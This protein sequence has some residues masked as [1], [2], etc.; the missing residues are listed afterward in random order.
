MNTTSKIIVTSMTLIVIIFFIVIWQ[1]QF[2]PYGLSQEK[3]KEL[4][5]MTFNSKQ[6]AVSTLN[7][8][9]NCMNE[10]SINDIKKGTIL[11]D[12]YVF[13]KSSTDDES[14]NKIYTVVYPTNNGYKIK[15]LEKRLKLDTAKSG[16]RMVKLGE[17]I[18]HYYIGHDTNNPFEREYIRTELGNVISFEG[19]QEPI[20]EGFNSKHHTI[21]SAEREYLQI[22]QLKNVDTIV[23]SEN[24][25]GKDLLMIIHYHKNN[26]EYVDIIDLKKMNRKYMINPL[27]Q[28]V[29]I[30]K[31]MKIFESSY[32]INEHTLNVKI[33]NREI[34]QKQHKINHQLNNIFIAADY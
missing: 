16:T 33:S 27:E 18:I 2:Q 14:S 20:G 12:V 28:E 8:Y 3:A 13:S 17:E 11:Y 30:S 6:S 23:F 15:I 7:D 10:M 1:K 24:E 26:K 21:A 32:Q 4:E 29:M 19:N 22:K 31:N 34:D 9:C 25:I 5:A